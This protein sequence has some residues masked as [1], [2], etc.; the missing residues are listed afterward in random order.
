MK[1]AHIGPS[2]LQRM[3]SGALHSDISP[4]DE[5]TVIRGS[6]V[7]HLQKLLNVRHG[8]VLIC[9]E[10]GLPDFND[11]THSHMNAVLQISQAIRKCIEE[12]EPR[13]RDV[14]VVPVA[15]NAGVAACF[16]F[17][18]TAHLSQRHPSM[19]VWFETI[20]EADGKALVRS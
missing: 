12:Y 11:I 20:L 8:S 13:L 15:E 2:I 1:N 6:I 10:Y 14:C 4:E 5:S 18:I 3:R 7:E 16:K 19:A 17:D 9:P